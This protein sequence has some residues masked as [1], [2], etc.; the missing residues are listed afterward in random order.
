MPWFATGMASAR[1]RIDVYSSIPAYMQ[2]ASIL[3]KQI[4]TGKLTPGDPLPS[5][6]TL[7]Q[8][9]EVARG[10]VRKAIEAIRDHGLIV[11]VQGR[12][13]FVKPSEL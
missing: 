1:P 8:E 13:S 12:G 2:L 10:T 3:R 4:E 7:M 6:T 5:E 11:T 9:Y